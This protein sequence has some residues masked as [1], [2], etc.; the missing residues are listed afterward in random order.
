MRT[1]QNTGYDVHAPNVIRR[2]AKTSECAKTLHSHLI[3]RQNLNF[4]VDQPSIR[5]WLTNVELIGIRFSF[6]S[7]EDQIGS[8]HSGD[9][10]VD[11]LELSALGFHLRRSIFILDLTGLIEALKRAF[12]A[13]LRRWRSVEQEICNLYLRAITLA[14][15]LNH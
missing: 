12:L 2:V 4:E 6:F 7:L 10:F 13:F 3:I 14:T 9:A 1:P 5:P 11:S 8:D 15:C